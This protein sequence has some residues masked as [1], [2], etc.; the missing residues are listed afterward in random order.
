MLRKVNFDN[1]RGS[2]RGTLS[3][4]LAETQ[5][6]AGRKKEALATYQSIAADETVQANQRQLA[7]DA[8]KALGK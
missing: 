4:A 6:A 1:L 8:I 2:W 5:K 3:L 7:Q